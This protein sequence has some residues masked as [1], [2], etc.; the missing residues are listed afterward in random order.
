MSYYKKTIEMLL[1][2][3]NTEEELTKKQLN[4]I[5][6]C[7]ALLAECERVNKDVYLIIRDS[8]MLVFIWKICYS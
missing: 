1:N 2:A 5:S 7:F 3:L 8:L 6:Q 4:I